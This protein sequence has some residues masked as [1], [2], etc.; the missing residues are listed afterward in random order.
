LSIGDT[1]CNCDSANFVIDL[2][3]SFESDDDIVTTMRKSDTEIMENA[4]R[5]CE[6]HRPKGLRWSIRRFFG[7]LFQ[8]VGDFFFD[9]SEAIY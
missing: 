4:V 3:D 8:K 1:K 6:I 5:F 7:K 2:V 9:L